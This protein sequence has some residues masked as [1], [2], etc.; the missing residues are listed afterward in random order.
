M[1]DSIIFTTVDPKLCKKR[2]GL[3]E[4][5]ILEPI[6]LYISPSEVMEMF[7]NIENKV[8]NNQIL[9]SKEELEFIIIPIFLGDDKKK[10]IR[11]ISNTF[12]IY[13]YT[14]LNIKFN[15]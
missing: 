1:A 7:N 15:I 5:L 13:K 12:K 10:E 11:I 14:I 3:T 4:T 2:I 8:L 9:S 6:H